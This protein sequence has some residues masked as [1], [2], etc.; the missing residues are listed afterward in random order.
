[1]F[2][3]NDRLSHWLI[4][5]LLGWVVCSILLFIPLLHWVLGVPMSIIVTSASIGC[6]IQLLVTPWLFSARSTKEN[7]AGNVLRRSAAVIVWIT[8]TILLFFWYV[9]RFWPE[10]SEKQ[11]FEVIAYSM[12]IAAGVIGL[13]AVGIISRARRLPHS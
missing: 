2:F 5:N 7:Q 13:I 4:G 12:T 8:T 3:N 1:M 11:S 6:G 9:Q 10:N